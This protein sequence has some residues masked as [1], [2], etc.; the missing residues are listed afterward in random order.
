MKVGVIGVG[1]L[2]QAMIELLAP[3]VQIVAYDTRNSEPRPSAELSSCDYG[4]I[5]V[6]TPSRDNGSCDTRRVEA[7]VNETPIE[8]LLLAST[9]SPGTTDSLVKSTGKQICHWPAV[10]RET[11]Y[12]DAVW[13]TKIADVPYAILGGEKTVR[14]YFLD[15]LVPILGP[16]KKYIQ[17]KAREAE[18]MKY[19]I[20]AFLATKVTFA[21]EFYDI[22]HALDVD[23]NIVRE[24]WLADPRVGRSHSAVFPGDRGFGGRCMPKD[25]LAIITAAKE[26]GAK[27]D[28]LDAVQAKNSNTVRK[29]S[30][31]RHVRRS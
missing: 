16:S 2:G 28:L 21:D 27:V 24:G 10:I 31:D 5:C 15:C 17:C 1:F 7:A 23:W 12:I 6:E 13:S 19:M 4:V 3:F 8:R 30:D 11:T 22:C 25:L 9:V 18:L 20:N 26:A 29:N 14:G